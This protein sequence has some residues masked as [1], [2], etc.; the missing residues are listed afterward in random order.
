MYDE[1]IEI[2][3][4]GPLRLFRAI[5]DRI[6]I[7]QIINAAV[8]WDETQWKISPGTLVAAMMMAVFCGRR[9]LFSLNKLYARQDLELLF[10]RTDLSAE[11][12]NDDCLGRALDRLAEAD[13]NAIFGGIVLQAFAEYGLNSDTI[14]ADTTSVSVYGDYESRDEEEPLVLARGHS[15]DHRPDLKQFKYG[16]ATNGDGIPIY[17]ETL[18]GN[19]DDKKWSRDFLEHA[20]DLKRFMTGKTVIVA[21]AAA[22]SGKSLEAIKRYRL[23]VVSRLPETFA[24][25][26]ELTE[27]AFAEGNWQPSTHAD[28]PKKNAAYKL[29]PFRA[30]LV[31]GEYSFVVVQSESLAGTKEKTVEKAVAKEADQLSKALADFGKKRFGS[32]DEAGAAWS[33]EAA[34][35]AP[36]YHTLAFAFRRYEEAIVRPRPGR[37]RKGEKARYQ[38][39]YGIEGTA[40]RDEERIQRTKDMEGTFVLFCSAPE[41]TPSEML[42][43]YKE[44][45]AVENRFR[46][47]KSPYFVG[48]VDLKLPRRVKALGYV[49]LMTLLVYSLFEWS[50]REGL[51]RENEPY[52]VAGSYRT[53]RPR[54][55]TVL[56]ELEDVAIYTVR[57]PEGVIRK[58]PANY[59]RQTE[60]IVRLCGFDMSIY[61]NSPLES[62][63]VV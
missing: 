34:H 56:P 27:R 50:V 23:R 29:Q 32:M 5:M 31:N 61:V 10:G 63:V 30:H 36:R 12:F 46:F 48:P 8:K 17:G 62:Q 51:K 54:G 57:G 6:G 19:Y 37:P 20:P 40:T 55:D 24:L 59:S 4:V 44:Q 1:N 13:F 38:T 15:K 21:D 18:D 58:L 39:L 9:A 7:V 28:D 26:G 47:L 2:V 43:V 60:R 35:L 41:L 53:F 11:D 25:C 52:H 14:H 42:R 16:L 45:A 3:K 22:M 33:L 49:M